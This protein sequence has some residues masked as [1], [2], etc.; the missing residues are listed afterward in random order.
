MKRMTLLSLLLIAIP[1]SAQ[2][3]SASIG[4]GPFVFGD[5]AEFSQR[6]SNGETTIQIE[7]SISA[8]TRPGLSASIDRQFNDR[9][10]LRFELTFTRAP[11]AIK[12]KTRGSDDD[13]VRVEIGEL[14][15]MTAA[16]PFVYRVNRAGT[17][18]PYVLA[19]PAYALY[20][21]QAKDGADALFRGSRGRAGVVAGGG[22]EWW[23]KSRWILRGEIVD[24]VT[25]SPLKRS[26]FQRGAPRGLEIP[27][28][29]NIHS[30]VALVYR[31][32][33]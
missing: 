24:I 6:I 5:F 31:F 25:K 2:D 15:A 30:L 8:S 1:C 3:W 16:L 29:H 23:W 10:S 14:S 12:S 22:I 32:G 28:T 33:S 21:H 9:S 18:R 20:D 26:D 4:T 11:M 13:G 7:Q 27:E 17:F 19:G